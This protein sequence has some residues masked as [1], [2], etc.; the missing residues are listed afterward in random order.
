M[1]RARR[2]PSP[3]ASRLLGDDIVGHEARK[4]VDGVVA[5]ARLEQLYPFP[6]AAYDEL[7]S[8]YPNI[9]EVV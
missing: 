7:L 2:E 9:S 6:L 4:G 3:Q 5:V 8:R 1:P